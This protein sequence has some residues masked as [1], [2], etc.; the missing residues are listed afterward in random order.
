MT[1]LPAT[2]QLQT[3]EIVFAIS[4]VA[5]ATRACAARGDAPTARLLGDYYT[6]A[7]STTRHAGGKVIKVMGDSI[8][9]TF[10]RPRAH[11][12]ITALRSLQQQGT[13]LW[14]RFDARC[15]VQLKVGVGPV[16]TGLF[17]PAGDERYDIYGDALN[18]LFKLP[19]ED[20]VLSP[21]MSLLLS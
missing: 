5:G 16:I 10:P 17:G 21:E 9:M 3:S 20:F 13:E 6:L 2:S 15:R 12:A 19:A 11:D 7:A 1:S 14:Q 18:R 4:A 8:L